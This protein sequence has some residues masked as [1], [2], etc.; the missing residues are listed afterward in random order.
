MG[1][2]FSQEELF[3]DKLAALGRRLEGVEAARQACAVR[4][5][6]AEAIH[7]AEWVDLQQQH[8]EALNAKVRGYKAALGVWS[9]ALLKGAMCCAGG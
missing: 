2:G 1:F 8:E 5:E 6:E 3:L 4:I 9:C 7:K